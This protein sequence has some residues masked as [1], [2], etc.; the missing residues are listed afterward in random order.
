[1]FLGFFRFGGEDGI[2]KKA[3]EAGGGGEGPASEAFQKKAAVQL[4][5]ARSALAG[6][7][8]WTDGA[9]HGQGVVRNSALVRRAQRRSRMPAVD[10]A[11]RLV[12]KASAAVASSMSGRR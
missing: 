7:R 2:L 3:G 8:G 12:R 11:S 9:A 4:V 1:M 6:G 5:V 10:P